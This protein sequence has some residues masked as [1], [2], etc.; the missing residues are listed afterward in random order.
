MNTAM[1]AAALFLGNLNPMPYPVQEGVATYYTYPDYGNGALYA[2]PTLT[3]RLDHNVE[4]CAVN[5]NAFLDGSVRPGDKLVVTFI[6][7]DVSLFLE[8]W[9]AG[10]FDGYYVEDFHSLPIIVDIPQHLW[11]LTWEK[12]ARVQIVNLSSL[13]RSIQ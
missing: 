12:S 11:P 7:Y 10:P 6:D 1:I 3:Y 4:W 13:H 5:V 9:D 2:H 8:A